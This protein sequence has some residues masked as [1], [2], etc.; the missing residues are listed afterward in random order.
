MDKQRNSV[1]QISYQKFNFPS[2]ILLPVIAI[3]TT[4]FKL[5][6]DLMNKCD[7]HTIFFT[8]NAR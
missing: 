4:K 7:N 3:T 6:L 1:K 8:E 2:Q 5:Q